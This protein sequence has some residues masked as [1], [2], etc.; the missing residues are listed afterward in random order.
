MKFCAINL[1]FAGGLFAIG[2]SLNDILLLAFIANYPKGEI[3]LTLE[4]LS[5]NLQ[6]STRTVFDCVVNLTNSGFIDKKKTARFSRL[7][8]AEPRKK[9]ALELVKTQKGQN[10]IILYF[11]KLKALN[12]ALDNDK[13]APLLS[14]ATAEIIANYRNAD[15][16][17][18][19]DNTNKVAIKALCKT[20]KIDLRR[21]RKLAA[22]ITLKVN[23]FTFEAYSSTKTPDNLES[24][25]NIL[26]VMLEGLRIYWQKKYSMNY[27][28]LNDL[29]KKD[30]LA[31]KQIG[32]TIMSKRG[33]KEVNQPLILFD[34]INFFDNLPDYWSNLPYFN[35]QKIAESLSNI[36]AARIEEAN[37]RGEQ[38]LPF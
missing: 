20:L 6:L 18:K 30:V 21:V 24:N 27:D 7:S 17:M 10:F 11:H 37:K 28:G 3:F 1:D 2:L 35:L 8:L 25:N 5:E 13:F 16:L 38:N 15:N 14:Y 4:G 23:L 33:K 22:E 29:S 34:V 31:L 26:L 19:V 36:Y 32:Y 9:E 12:I